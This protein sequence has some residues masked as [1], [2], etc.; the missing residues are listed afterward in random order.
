MSDA[1]EL[2]GRLDLVI[3]ITFATVTKG[4]YWRPM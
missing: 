3:I 1:A 4:L 2:R